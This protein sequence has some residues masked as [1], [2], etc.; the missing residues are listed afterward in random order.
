MRAIGLGHKAAKLIVYIDKRPPVE[1]LENLNSLL[2]LDK[3]IL[4]SI[5]TTGNHWRKIINI[6]A[7][8][9]FLLDAKS[10]VTWQQYRDEKLLTAQGD[11]ALLFNEQLVSSDAIHLISGKT[12]FDKFELDHDTFSIMD[13]QGKIYR[14][15]NVFQ[16]PYFDYRQFPNSLIDEL[17]SVIRSLY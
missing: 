10:C 5:T 11:E 1:S 2:C 8:I 14:Y 9:A 6:M 17:T 7:K 15:G 3:C 16:T 12:F 4:D 13:K